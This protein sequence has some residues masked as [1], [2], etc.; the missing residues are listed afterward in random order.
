MASDHPY[1]GVTDEL[2]DT[3]I[4][5]VPAGEHDISVWHESL[6]RLQAHVIVPSNGEAA[7]TF[8]FHEDGTNHARGMNK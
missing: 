1:F 2:G 7:V 6:G 8:T 3:R 4:L 5:D